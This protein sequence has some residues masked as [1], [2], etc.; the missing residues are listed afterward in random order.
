MAYDKEK[1]RVKTAENAKEIGLLS[2]FYLGLKNNYNRSF[3]SLKKLF[4]IL[5][6]S[7]KAV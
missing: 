7:Y 1:F 3:D 5:E 6:F 2:Y 4:L